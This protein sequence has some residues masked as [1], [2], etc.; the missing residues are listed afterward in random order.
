M[1]QSPRYRRYHKKVGANRA[2]VISQKGHRVAVAAEL[3]DILFDPLKGGDDVEEAEIGYRL[4][5]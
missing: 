1:K 5:I 3:L 4:I 2:R